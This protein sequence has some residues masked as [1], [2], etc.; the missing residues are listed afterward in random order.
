[1]VLALRLMYKNQ[2]FYKQN[3]GVQNAY[4]TPV[5]DTLYEKNSENSSQTYTYTNHGFSIELPKGFTPAEY[6]SEGGPYI[7]ITLPKTDPQQGDMVYIQN[8][9]W[10]KKYD[11]LGY[12]YVGTQ[13]IGNTE[14]KKYQ[15]KVVGDNVIYVFT[16]G[17]VGYLFSNVNFPLLETFNFV[18]WTQ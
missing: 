10:W 8:M 3:L 17:N 4:Q 1:M 2:E 9:D 13:K 12:T 18:G 16:Q 6:E 14:F 7:T 11:G 15:S 5:G